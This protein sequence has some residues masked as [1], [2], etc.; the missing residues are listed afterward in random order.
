MKT[1]ILTAIL[2]FTLA[3]C[4]AD[5]PPTAPTKAE[6]GLAITGSTRVGMVMQ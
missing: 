1:L 2:T 5:G 3:A 4:G 6:N